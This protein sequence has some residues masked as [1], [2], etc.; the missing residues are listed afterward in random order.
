M[1]REVSKGMKKKEGDSPNLSRGAQQLNQTRRNRRPSDA[2]INRGGKNFATGNMKNPSRGGANRKRSHQP[3][4]GKGTDAS[5]K[6]KEGINGENEYR[7]K[8][9]GLSDGN[10]T[11]K[12]KRVPSSR[13][14][15]EN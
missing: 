10:A 8:W 15:V 12:K 6:G 9:E 1:K 2:G 4:L 3:V 7:G 14:Q 11:E 5:R 13:T